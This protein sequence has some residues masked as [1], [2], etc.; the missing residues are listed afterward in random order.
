MKTASIA[1]C[2]CVCLAKC[3]MFV[4]PF[5]MGE[6][7]SQHAPIDLGCP[8]QRVS[9]MHHYGNHSATG[10][11]FHGCGRYV[12]YHCMSLVSDLSETQCVPVAIND[13]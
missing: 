4:A 2:A 6:V 8:S 1:I 9:P 12:V 13:E 10:P 5:K 3:G 11:A 7:A